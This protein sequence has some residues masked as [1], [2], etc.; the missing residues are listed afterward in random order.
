MSKLTRLSWKV[1]LF[2]VVIVYCLFGFFP[3][4]EILEWGKPSCV[5]TLEYSMWNKSCKLAHTFILEF[6]K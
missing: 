5:S 1:V 6:K 2:P 4:C 3:L